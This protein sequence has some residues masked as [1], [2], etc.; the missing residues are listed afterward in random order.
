MFL[1]QW[2]L[3][4]SWLVGTHH[5][6][7]NLSHCASCWAVFLDET[8]EDDECLC[9]LTPTYS[10][11]QSTC[12]IIYQSDVYAYVSVLSMSACIYVYVYVCICICMCIYIYICLYMQ[13]CTCVYVGARRISKNAAPFLLRISGA[14]LKI[15]TQE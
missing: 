5:Q 4:S 6:Q 9:K 7:D 12:F 15:R 13:V 3:T 14:L 2:T 11:P 10:A 1:R 8:P